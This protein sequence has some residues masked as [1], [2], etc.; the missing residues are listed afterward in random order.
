MKRLLLLGTLLF[1]GCTCMCNR[2]PTGI[3]QIGTPAQGADTVIKKALELAPCQP[4]WGVGGTVTWNA[5]GCACALPGNTD[6]RYTHANGCVYGTCKLEICV[7]PVSTYA[8]QTALAHE[9]GEYFSTACHR[10]WTQD[11]IEAWAQTVNT[12]AAV[13]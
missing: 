7:A 1:G 4:D 9:F 2:P 10:N 5:Q 3:T 11:Q 8:T 6:T 13:P 12:A